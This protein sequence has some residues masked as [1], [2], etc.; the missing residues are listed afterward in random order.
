MILINFRS[1]R[2]VKRA[3]INSPCPAKAVPFGSAGRSRHRPGERAR[4]DRGP[5][6]TKGARASHTA[7]FRRSRRARR[8]FA[9]WLG[10][11]RGLQLSKVHRVFTPLPSQPTPNG[12]ELNMTCN[13]VD[14]S[15]SKFVR[16]FPYYISRIRYRYGRIA[17]TLLAIY[18]MA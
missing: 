4:G 3:D 6:S 5:A 14:Y 18:G 12:K 10:R 9:G 13:G 11:D 17:A 16:I 8:P 2:R 15:F 7:A 1:S